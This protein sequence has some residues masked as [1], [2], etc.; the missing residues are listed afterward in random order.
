MCNVAQQIWQIDS[1]SALTFSIFS[2]KGQ[3]SLHLYMQKHLIFLSLG[4]NLM[5]TLIFVYKLVQ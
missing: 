1:I 5:C 4:N 2:K 3:N